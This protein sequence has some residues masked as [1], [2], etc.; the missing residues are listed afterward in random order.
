M[1]KFGFIILRHV[2]SAK[3]NE[4]WQE[5]YKCIRNVYPDT[6]IVIIDDDSNR[7][8]VTNRGVSLINTI[9][10][11][12]EFKKRGELLPYYYY[13]QNKWF[14][15]AVILHDSVFIKADIITREVQLNQP[16]KMLWHFVTH[17][18]DD[19]QYIVPLIR[20]LNDSN[21]L[22]SFYKTKIWNGCF[23]GMAIVNHD[24]L[25]GLDHKYNIYNLL[26]KITTRNDR[27]A[28]E[29]V[30]ACMFQFE[31][32]EIHFGLL[33]NINQ[34]CKW[35]YTFEEYIVDKQNLKR[36]VNIYPVIKVWSGR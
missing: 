31:K 13:L 26:S 9:I 1:D 23:G 34:Y 35:G 27:M 2:D 24:F 28:F 7:E 8:F 19:D 5:C 12:S 22:L 36:L 17:Q 18:F 14:E 10:I 3:T 32:R 25:Q 33:Q 30:I 15:N 16:Y 29:R 11:D 21:K 6:K 4:Y 20:S